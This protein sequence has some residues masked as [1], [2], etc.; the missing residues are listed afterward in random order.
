MSHLLSSVCVCVCVRE[1]E[2]EREKF[3]DNQIDVRAIY[4]SSCLPTSSTHVSVMIPIPTVA[5]SSLR[6]MR[7][8]VG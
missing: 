7:P 4:S 1:R 5:P 6:T 3:I 8:S 2:R